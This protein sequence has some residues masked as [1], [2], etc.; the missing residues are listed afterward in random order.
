M[1][2]P[3]KPLDE[4]QLKLVWELLTW[5]GRATSNLFYPTAWGPGEE[6]KDQISFNFNY[7]VIF[8]DFYTKLCVCTHKWKMQNISD[9]VLILS[10]GLCPRGGSLGAGG[11][12]GVKKSNLVCDISNRWGWRAEKNVSKIFIP[13]VKM[14]TLA[15]GQRVKYH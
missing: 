7:K 3:S 6:S 4:I 1:L 11:A 10:P 15:W 14:V 5:I 12:Q 9:G 2:S 13:R 8:K